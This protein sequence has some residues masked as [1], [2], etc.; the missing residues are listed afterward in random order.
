MFMEKENNFDAAALQLF[1]DLERKNKKIKDFLVDN[2]KG[3]P[4]DP[5]VEEEAHEYFVNNSVFFS[6]MAA[7]NA[8]SMVTEFLYERLPS[9]SIL[10][11][12][13]LN[14]KAGSAIRARIDAVEDE[15]HK[16]IEEYHP[17]GEVLIGNL[18]S[19]PGRDVIDVLS[20]Y[21]QNFSNIRAINIDRD[22]TALKR[23]KRMASIKKVDHLIDFVE[24]SFLKYEP[25]KKFDIVI[26]VGILCTLQNDVCVNIL[27][28]VKGLLK[29]DGCLIVSNVAYK[30]K[31]DDPF[32]CYI[33]NWVA[34]WNFVYKN[35]EKL[36]K[37]L[38]EAGYQWKRSF[39]DSYGFHLM[40]IVTQKL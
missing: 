29:K 6:A 27:K 9:Q 31:E 11:N 28:T 8:S 15:L 10:D 30:M 7:Q 20:K 1:K 39:T 23:G 12:Y 16:V 33:M 37:I 25:E 24:G 19:G 34:N 2:Y 21:Y 35:E 5:H 26:L 3:L 18:G 38:D 13:A 14:S 32:A 17:K 22:V 36:K 40:G 4:P